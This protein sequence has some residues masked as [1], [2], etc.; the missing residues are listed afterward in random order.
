MRRVGKSSL[1]QMIYGKIASTNKTLLDIENPLD[2]SIFEEK[3]YNNIIKNLADFGI[4]PDHKAYIFLDEIQ[5]YPEIVKPI[6]YLYD[7]YDIKFIV[8]GSSSFYLK[9][10]FP[11]SLAGRKVEFE[12]YPLDFNEFL[13]FKGVVSIKP[14]FKTQIEFEKTRTKY[15]KYIRWY[16]EYLIHG[17]FHKLCWLKIRN[18]KLHISE[19]F[20]KPIFKLICCSFQMLKTFPIYAIL[21]YYL[22]HVPAQR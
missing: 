17:D 9:N 13:Y 21:Y 20:L 8:T 7:H 1:L 10:L 22:R 18:K 3:D 15:E 16:D 12:L 2:R 14:A 6:K 4:H 5:A 11:E 19:I